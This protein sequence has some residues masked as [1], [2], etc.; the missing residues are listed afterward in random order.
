MKIFYHARTWHLNVARNVMGAPNMYNDVSEDSV[1]NE[2][3][4]Q[5]LILQSLTFTEQGRPMCVLEHVSECRPITSLCEHVRR[6]QSLA[7][8][9]FLF[10]QYTSKILH[11]Y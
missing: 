1:E 7:W 10:L 8:L 5:V 6:K 2:I 9:E 3:Y 4:I 11:A